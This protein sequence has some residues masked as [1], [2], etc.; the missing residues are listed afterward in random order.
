MMGAS[1]HAAYRPASLNAAGSI[2]RLCR[3]ANLIAAM[4]AAFLFSSPA[5]AANNVEIRPAESS[6]PASLKPGATAAVRIRMVNNGTTVWSP[7]ALQRLG[8]QFSGTVNQVTWS[9]F[10]C[11]GY[12]NGPS[13]ARAFLCSPVPPGSAQDITFD[14]TIPAN[15]TGS[16]RL[17]VRMVQD[18][19]EWFGS[20]YSW[21]IAVSPGGLPDVVVDRV[22]LSPPNPAPGQ[23]VSFSALVR[24][25]ARLPHRLA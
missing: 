23:P 9:N 22:S 25:W 24:N 18:G 1:N 19:V 5:G 15:A 4:A 17:A 20:A 13:D 8:A 21:S 16:A 2:T 3:W 12:M 14:I 11:G 7:A 10:R 6:V